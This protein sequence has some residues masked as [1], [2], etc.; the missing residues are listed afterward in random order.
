MRHFAITKMAEHPDM[1][2]A[3]VMSI[4]GHV[5]KKMLEHY[6]HIRAKAKAAAVSAIDTFQIPG[7]PTE[8]DYKRV[9]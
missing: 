5:S 4:A 6:A 1:S 7:Q 8:T 3:T 9:N 2:D